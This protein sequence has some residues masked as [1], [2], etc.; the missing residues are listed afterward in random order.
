[1]GR[2]NTH[3]DV[4]DDAGGGSKA[5]MKAGP[6]KDRLADGWEGEKEMERVETMRAFRERIREQRKTRCSPQV[7]ARPNL[8]VYLILSAAKPVYT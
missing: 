1:M 6:H 7:T 4:P 5:K 2:D 8:S 3:S